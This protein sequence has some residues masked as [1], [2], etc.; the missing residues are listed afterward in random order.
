MLT[1][2]TRD[3]NNF[4]AKLVLLGN[5]NV[6][7]TSIILRLKEDQFYERKAATVGTR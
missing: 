1:S 6:G 5:S 2:S 3:S 7:K 4:E